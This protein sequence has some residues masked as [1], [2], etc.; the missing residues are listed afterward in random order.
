MTLRI[1]SPLRSAEGIS[2]CGASRWRVFLVGWTP[3]FWTLQ[4]QNRKT[5]HCVPARSLRNTAYCARP[6]HAFYVDNILTRSDI[7]LCN[8]QWICR[9]YR[10]RDLLSLVDVYV[11][12]GAVIIYPTILPPYFSGGSFS[13]RLT[14]SRGQPRAI[15]ARSAEKK[16]KRPVLLHTGY[17]E[18]HQKA[19]GTCSL[20]KVISAPFM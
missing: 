19:N 17:G 5:S 11:F 7:S 15:L 6:Q 13:L 2:R 12:V 8:E 4:V 18:T 20:K 3:P 10:L 14:L 9:C 1:K 16:Q